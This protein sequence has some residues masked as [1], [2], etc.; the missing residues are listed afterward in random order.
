[1]PRLR[2]QLERTICR[3]PAF[4]LNERAIGLHFRPTKHPKKPARGSNARGW[5]TIAIVMG[6]AIAIFVSA[7]NR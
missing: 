2:M 4:S 1:V 5:I 3:E 6:F 7:G